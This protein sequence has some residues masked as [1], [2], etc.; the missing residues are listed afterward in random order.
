MAE[1]GLADE[2]YD[3]ASAFGRVWAFIS[4]IFATIIGIVLIIAGIHIIRSKKDRH[5]V[6][7]TITM[8]NGKPDGRCDTKTISGDNYNCGVDF[9]YVEQGKEYVKNVYYTGDKQY[10]GGEPIDVYVKDDNPED[11]VLEAPISHNVGWL[12]IVL[13]IIIVAGSWFWYWASTKWK[14]VGVASGV[15][16]ISSM[17]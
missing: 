5:V 3:D 9:K 17:F 1:K 2:I 15:K 12:L 14:V 7:A 4:A 16:G 8:I 6:K 10:Y 13:S 11:A